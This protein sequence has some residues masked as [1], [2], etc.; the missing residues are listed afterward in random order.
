M[1]FAAV[2][3]V[4]LFALSGVAVAGKREVDEVR[5]RS[6]MSMVVTG[7]IRIKADGSVD[8]VDLDK[9]GEL[10]KGVVE[11]VQHT[12]PGWR[13]EPATASE[14]SVETLNMSV[15]LVGR[16]RDNGD[17]ELTMRSAHFDEPNP[18]TVL[19]G[20]S[21]RPP[22]YPSALVS[23]NAAGTV[24][25]LVRVDEA[26]EAQEVFA[27]Q[28]NLSVVAEEK[29]ML[30]LREEFARSAVSGAKRWKFELRKKEGD[31]GPWTARVP[32]EYVR[33][34]GKPLKYGQWEIYVPGPRQ[35]APWFQDED[36]AGLG[37]DA[38]ADDKPQLLGQGRRL[39]TK[40]AR[41]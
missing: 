40:L 10:P 4:M 13:F 25:V 35:R 15:R 2:A 29:E 18:G 6:E 26:G 7:K 11:L 8:G 19:K 27:E 38:F 39:L 37:V 33:P 3:A 1:K 17:Y 32:L 23:T 24:Y 16:K 22:S 14:A 30:R 41:E 20:L 34:G 9:P 31:S 21:M 5:A 36:T 12:V 28:I